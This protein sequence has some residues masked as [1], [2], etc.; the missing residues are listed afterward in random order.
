MPRQ[1]NANEQK[2]GK[3]VSARRQ[4]SHRNPSGSAAA[5]R[6]SQRASSEGAL[7]EAHDDQLLRELRDAE[8]RQRIHSASHPAQRPQISARGEGELHLHRSSR[9]L[10][11]ARNA[12]IRHVVSLRQGQAGARSGPSPHPLAPASSGSRAARAARV[13][14]GI[15]DIE[16]HD[17]AGHDGNGN[18]G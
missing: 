17:H 18:A 1:C 11:P 7:F 16:G 12:R 4:P 14:Q 9:R 2:L 13:V 5:K 8:L 6:P 3:E 10:C 15:P